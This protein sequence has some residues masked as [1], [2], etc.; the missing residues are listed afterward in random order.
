MKHIN[1][2][3]SVGYKDIELKRSVVVAES[4]LQLIF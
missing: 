1:A 4:R 2:S 3:N